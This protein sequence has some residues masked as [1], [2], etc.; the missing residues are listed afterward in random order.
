MS[1]DLLS[2]DLQLGGLCLSIAVG[3]WLHRSV[4]LLSRTSITGMPRMP[5]PV[6]SQIGQ[7]LDRH[8]GGAFDVT[9]RRAVIIGTGNY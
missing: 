3:L 2:G 1:T 5:I 7:F 4:V 9:Q 6:V 8:L